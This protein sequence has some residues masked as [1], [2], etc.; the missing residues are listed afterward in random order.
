MQR[1]HKAKVAEE[2]VY[3]GGDAGE[4]FRCHTD[5]AHKAAAAAGV[6]RHVNGGAYAQGHGHKQG[7]NRHKYGVNKGGQQGV[8][9]RGEFGGEQLR[10]KMRQTLYKDI[11]YEKKQNAGGDRGGAHREH[12]QNDRG[13]ASA[14]AYCGVSCVF[15][16]RGVA[17]HIIPPYILLRFFIR[18]NTRFISSIKANS[19]AAVAISA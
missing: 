9:L 17:F 18:A 14:V 3:Y 1:Y 4:G 7:Q 2:P 15:R 5:Y 12:P 19:T 11:T 10:R 13:G 6:F 16:Q 8:V